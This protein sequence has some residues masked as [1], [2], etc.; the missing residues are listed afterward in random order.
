M[1]KTHSS[2]TL[3]RTRLKLH[4]KELAQGA[5]RYL[6]SAAFLGTTLGTATR[7]PWWVRA[8]QSSTMWPSATGS[9]ALPSRA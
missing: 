1:H 2:T 8:W 4:R 5:A 6:Y 9:V 7:L 3:R